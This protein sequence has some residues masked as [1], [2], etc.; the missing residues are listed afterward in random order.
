[1]KWKQRQKLTYGIS[2]QA[3]PV[4]A[5]MPPSGKNETGRREHHFLS[6]LHNEFEV[7]LSK[8]PWPCFKINKRLSLSC[9][10]EHCCILQSSQL[11]KVDDYFSSP[12]RFLSCLSPKK[13]IHSIWSFGVCT[14]LISQYSMIQVCGVFSN[15]AL[16]SSSRAIFSICGS[17]PLEV[18]Q[19]F[20]SGP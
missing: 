13:N 2:K 1:M 6:G 4:G 12:D 3:E 11:G 9:S 17:Q 7:H 8:L 19:S 5:R 15:R 20:H 10:V 14:I 16:L 18:E